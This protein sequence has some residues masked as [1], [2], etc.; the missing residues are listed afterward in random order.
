MFFCST[1]FTKDRRTNNGKCRTLLQIEISKLYTGKSCLIIDDMTEMRGML[2]RMIRGF[3]MGEVVSA[4][5]ATEAIDACTRQSF[6]VVICDYN[7]GT[8]KDGQQV[9]EEM[10]H[11]RILMF[12]SLFIMITA[13]TSRQMVLGAIECQPDD[14]LT[15]PFTQASLQQRMDKAMI[16]HDALL[17]IKE[18]VSEKKCELAIKLCDEMI[19]T[20]SR[21]AADCLKIKAHMHFLLNELDEAQNLYKEALSDRKQTWAQL[22]LAKTLIEADKLDQAEEVLQSIVKE[23]E[24]YIEAHDMLADIYEK[25]ENWEMAQET[26]EKATEISPKA[27]LRHRRLAEAATQTMDDFVALGAF[28]NAIKW[29]VNSVFES[30]QDSF[31]FSRKAADIIRTGQSDNVAGITDR[32]NR[33]IDRVKKRYRNDDELQAQ[34]DLVSAQ[35]YAAKDEAKQAEKYQTKGEEAAERLLNPSANIQLERAR[36]FKSVGETDQASEVLRDLVT[37][38][39]NDDSVMKSVDTISDEPMSKEGKRAATKLNKAGIERYENGDYSTAIT[40]FSEALA[41][42]PNHI[43][44]NLNLIQAILAQVRSTKSPTDSYRKRCEVCLNSIGELATD[45]KQRQRSEHLA[46]QVKTQFANVV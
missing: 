22:G 38:Y 2:S 25:R 31:N 4:A 1:L 13:E 15:K 19:E 27:V 14:Y 43:G 17:P 41:K 39:A 12:T 3:G 29:G 5:N 20:D 16:K 26:L 6:D 8:G 9:L 45:H 34:A 28:E 36:A 33:I 42:Y 11:L 18:A 35:L 23:D 37:D 46:Q 21:Y 24:R 7:L 40:I 32:T 10:R 44:L 30:P